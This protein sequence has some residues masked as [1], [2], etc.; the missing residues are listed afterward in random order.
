M[1]SSN[2]RAHRTITIL[3]YDHIYRH[4][5]FAFNKK[6]LLNSYR[7]SSTILSETEKKKD[8]CEKLFTIRQ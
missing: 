5:G 8:F 3:T 1:I 7:N 2:G 4:L 6:V